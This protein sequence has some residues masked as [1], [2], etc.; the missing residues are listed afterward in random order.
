MKSIIVFVVLVVFSVSFFGL[1]YFLFKPS[2]SNMDYQESILI[3]TYLL[4]E[5]KLVGFFSGNKTNQSTNSLLFDK[6]LYLIIS[7]KNI[8]N[9]A[10]WGILACKVENNT[11]QINV[12]HLKRKM[13]KYAHFV[14]PYF[15][16]ISRNKNLPPKISTK[17]IEMNTK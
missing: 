6:N 8:G 11:F 14:I 13:K 16:L 3:D 2:F 12:P 17:W 9:Q 5:E 10:A 7:L 1:K 4:E 15:G